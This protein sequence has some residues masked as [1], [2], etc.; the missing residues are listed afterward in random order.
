MGP[1]LCFVTL[2]VYLLTPVTLAGL[3]TCLS[4]MRVLYGGTGDSKYRACPLLVQYVD[5]GKLYPLPDAT[6]HVPGTFGILVTPCQLMVACER[7]MARE[8]GTQRG[9]HICAASKL[10]AWALPCLPIRA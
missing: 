7:R 6:L 4:I 9:V 5:A 10:R 3:D 1:E 8:E 2:A